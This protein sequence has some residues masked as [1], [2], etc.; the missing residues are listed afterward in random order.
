M[1]A[2]A[3]CVN[4]GSLLLAQVSHRGDSFGMWTLPGGGLEWGE[5]PE[6]GMHRELFEETG[7]RGEVRSLLGI[8]S[9]VFPDV[10]EFPGDVHSVRI[11]YEVEARGEP[12]VMEVDGTVQDSRWVRLDEVAGYPTVDLVH[13]ALGQA[14]WG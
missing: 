7:L 14:G 5:H 1:A 11:V 12:Q 13:F 2:Y 3:F 6:E 10:A 9:M 4:E 8:D